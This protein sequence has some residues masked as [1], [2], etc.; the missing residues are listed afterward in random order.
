MKIH[1]LLGGLLLCGL[2]ALALAEITSVITAPSGTNGRVQINTNNRFGSDSTLTYSTVTKTLSA[3][4]VNIMQAQNDLGYGL[5]IFGTGGLDYLNLYSTNADLAI[6]QSGDQSNYK[7][8][9]LN[10]YG[11]DVYV[12]NL[13]TKAPIVDIRAYGATGNGTDEATKIQNAMNAA[14]GGT[15]LVASGTWIT[16]AQ[17]TANCDVIGMGPGVSIIKLAAGA[18]ISGHIVLMQGAN[19]F[20]ENVGINGNADNGASAPY[21]LT[22]NS[23]R[24]LA[25]NVHVYNTLGA[26]IY[27]G[28]GDI[29]IKESVIEGLGSPTTAQIGILVTN[30]TSFRITGGIVKNWGINGIFESGM[31]AGV[32]IHAT[33]VTFSGNHRQFSPTGGGQITLPDTGHSTVVGCQFLLGDGGGGD[34][35]GTSAIE[36]EGEGTIAGNLFDGG[37]VH[38]WGIAMSHGSGFVITGNTIQNFANAGA[39]MGASVDYCSITG[40]V[41]RS[42][43]SNLVLSTQTH[44]QV[45]PNSGTDMSVIQTQ[46]DLTYGLRI[47]GTDGKDNLNLYSNNSD[48]GILQVADESTYRPLALNPYGG[49]VVIG[50]TTAPV[51]TLSVNGGAHI[52]GVSNPG[53][54]NL[55]VDGTAEITGLTKTSGGVHVG[56]SSDPGADN[57]IVDGTAEIATSVRIGTT[58]ANG[59]LY[60]YGG[61]VTIK[62]AADGF[63][64]HGLMVRGTGGDY[65]NLYATDS[66]TAGIQSGDEGA[67]RTFTL[68]ENGGD[69]TLG[70]ATGQID[71]P[72]VYAETT[73]S[74]ANVFVDTD[75]SLRR[76]TSSKRYKTNIRPYST[77]L[78]KLLQLKPVTYVGN[79]DKAK[80][81]HAGFLAE[82]VAALGLKEFVAYDSQKRPDSLEYGN[83][84]ALLVNAIKELSAKNDAL[85]KRLA[86]LEKE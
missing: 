5:R 21:G 80:K 35:T 2:P 44:N 75:G 25:S 12:R 36:A 71:A 85:E 8:L 70:S 16:S 22:L 73:A 34:S 4:N 53:D 48:L 65:V 64:F 74:A 79:N 61:D 1:R 55:L 27:A 83:L 60:V 10:P 58:T 63:P 9:S 24:V 45:G 40:N 59:K 26:G 46:N 23:S 77:G 30:V 56:G 19:T 18:T 39:G 11:G 20:I 17:L 57:L 76:S 62:Q 69:L 67:Y 7:G 14:S 41:F 50:T 72:P 43:G 54:D 42:N 68:N 52:G 66:N 33:G 28:T 29:E 78:S 13:I 15:L 81:L 49:K 37:G 31:T 6:I 32:G 51:A 3:T 82:D 86:I 38:A 47:F 84:A